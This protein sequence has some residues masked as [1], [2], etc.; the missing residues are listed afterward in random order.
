MK[1]WDELEKRWDANERRYAAER[2]AE[3]HSLTATVASALREAHPGLEEVIS[4]AA[5]AIN[6]LIEDGVIFARMGAV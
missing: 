3:W 4:V 2:L 5:T 1:S 6:A